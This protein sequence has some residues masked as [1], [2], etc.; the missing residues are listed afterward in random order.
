MTV[1]SKLDLDL[2]AIR[3]E[4][5]LLCLSAIGVIFRTLTE[6]L[7]PGPKI[8]A[9]TNLYYF[10]RLFCGEEANWIGE[11]HEKY[12]EVVRFAPGKL[13]YIS[14]QA[15][16]DIAGHRTGGRLEF[17]KDKKTYGP[18]INGD[19]NIVGE[20]TSESHSQVRRVFANA[21]SDKALKLQEPLIS[22]HV[23]KLKKIFD[24]HVATDPEAHIDLVRLFNCATF[25]IMGDLTFG[26]PL[27]MLDTGKYTPWVKA[28]FESIKVI[29]LFRL[30]KQYSA[31][32]FFMKALMPPS[33]RGKDLEHFRHASDRVDKRLEKGTDI[34][35]SDI[36]KLV[37][38]N[39]KVQLPLSKMHAN[40]SVF[41][42]AGTETTATLLSGM[43]Y[44]LLTHP[45]KLKKVV[46]EVRALP[47][48]DLS[49]EVLPRLQYL[50]A[51]FQEAFRLYP[52]VP[53]GL[54][55]QV[56]QGGGVICGEWV[57]EKTSVAV[58]QRAAYYSSKNFKDPND[59]VPERWLPGTGY[60]T[61]R[62]D[63]LQPF[64]FGPR[65]CIGKNLAYHEMRI[66]AAMLLWNYDL[67]LSPE[68]K[69]W[70]DQK[71]YILWDKPVLM[72]KLIPVRT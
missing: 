64:S 26:E 51:C 4:H 62:K 21:F 48:E 40:A 56:P 8:A 66:I 36:W 3:Q 42:I 57:P 30:A 28:V 37:I 23:N 43:T 58:S 1:L 63:V 53:I 68:S 59:F 46:E 61:D 45:D 47:K 32:G 67:E 50:S 49:L 55:R 33:I 10:Y 19:Y 18:D 35:K 65:N 29:A 13:S 60:D 11:C 15:W 38:E 22:F 27:G 9:A 31:L 14:P 71:A 39:Q 12:G 17:Q 7:V 52:P 69:N 24:K 2:G 41:M 16:K 54:P 25:D 6:N 20:P 72:V 70:I 34:G 5:V 44:L